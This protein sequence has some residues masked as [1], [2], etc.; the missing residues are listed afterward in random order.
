MVL[1]ALL[2]VV[3]AACSMTPTPVPTPVGVDPIINWDP[4]AVNCN[5]EAITGVRYNVYG[6]PGPGPIP[7]VTSPAPPPPSIP[8]EQPCGPVRLATGT[9][10][11]AAPLTA[12]TFNAIVPDGVWT[13]AVE[14]V[15]STGARGGLSEAVTVTVHN[16]GGVPTNVRVGAPTTP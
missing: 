2:I 14:T 15:L 8:L 3:S 7:A 6:V 5:G 9:P 12:T 11:N 16:R 10:L 13:F 1:L 4:V